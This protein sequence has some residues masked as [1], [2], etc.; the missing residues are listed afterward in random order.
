MTNPHDEFLHKSKTEDK[1]LNQ[2]I[3]QK[4]ESIQSGNSKGKRYTIP[5]YLAHI[6]RVLQES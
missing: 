6:D 5:E 3:E 1:R 2:S 4:I